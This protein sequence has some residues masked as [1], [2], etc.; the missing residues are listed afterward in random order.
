[1]TRKLSP[2]QADLLAR[3]R[4]SKSRAIVPE[5][6]GFWA[7]DGVRVPCK[8]QTVYALES[9]GVLVRMHTDARCYRDT[10]RI[11]EPTT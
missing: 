3:L 1:V 7:I 5:G 10:Y 9:R 6:G 4:G 8:T 11:Q 2:H